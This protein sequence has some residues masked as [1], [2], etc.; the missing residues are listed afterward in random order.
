[1]YNKQWQLTQTIQLSK[2]LP[3]LEQGKNDITFDGQYSGD[4]AP[5]VKIELRCKGT[6]EVLH[7]KTS[8]TL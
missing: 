8:K 2:P 7:S 5:N 4:N 6:P 3:T 1:L